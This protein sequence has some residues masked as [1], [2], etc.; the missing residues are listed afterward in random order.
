MTF[1]PGRLLMAKQLSLMPSSM[2]K[3]I[4]LEWQTGLG[5]VWRGPIYIVDGGVCVLYVLCG[6]KSEL[7][8]NSIS[9]AHRPRLGAESAAAAVMERPFCSRS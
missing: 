2:A 5:H 6:L 1:N 8:Q 9:P 7:Q 3:E 4:G